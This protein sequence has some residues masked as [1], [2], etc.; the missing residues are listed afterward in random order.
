MAKWYG[1]DIR[2]YDGNT[3]Q[4][5]PDNWYETYWTRWNYHGW[6]K[7]HSTVAQRILLLSKCTEHSTGWSQ[8]N[9]WLPRQLQHCHRKCS[10]WS[11][12]LEEERPLKLHHED[13]ISI[14]DV[15]IKPLPL[16]SVP[17]RDTQMLCNPEK[18]R[19]LAKSTWPILHYAYSP[20][21]EE[22]IAQTID[23][24]WDYPLCFMIKN[25]A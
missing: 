24:L 11:F 10:D 21:L 15:L 17:P 2:S 16:S 13:K 23:Y 22:T 14:K 4:N 7:L 25:C 19:E 18:Q 1:Y 8:R 20:L 9:L 12:N 5:G 3:N 6:T